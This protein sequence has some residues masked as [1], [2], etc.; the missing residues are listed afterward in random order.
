LLRGVDDRGL[1]E[2]EMED[3]IAETHVPYA[4]SLIGQR[5]QRIFSPFA[6]RIQPKFAAPPLYQSLTWYTI[7]D[8]VPNTQ[9][10]DQTMGS[11]GRFLAGD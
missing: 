9:I 4:L 1:L 3:I 7:I 11:P 6:S 8:G 10:D 2:Q 5:P